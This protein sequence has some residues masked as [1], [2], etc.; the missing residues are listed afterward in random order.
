MSGK[1]FLLFTLTHDIDKRIYLHKRTLQAG[2][3]SQ[4][5]IALYLKKAGQLDSTTFYS[6]KGCTFSDEK[7]KKK[8]Q[9]THTI[10]V[11]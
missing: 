8:K 4:F 9:N 3:F 10:F 1:L 5:S 11:I 7:V 6:V 2:W